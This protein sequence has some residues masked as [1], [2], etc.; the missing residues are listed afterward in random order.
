MPWTLP[1][2]KFPNVFESWLESTATFVGFLNLDILSAV[3]TVDCME[4]LH[5]RYFGKLVFVTEQCGDAYD[6]ITFLFRIQRSLICHRSPCLPLRSLCS[7]SS[8]SRCPSGLHVFEEVMRL[9]RLR[10]I[11]KKANRRIPPHQTPLTL[12]R[13]APRRWCRT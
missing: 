6:A 10:V 13:R 11:V 3:T 7:F 4:G 12:G 2:V 5:L 1:N 9:P 8:A